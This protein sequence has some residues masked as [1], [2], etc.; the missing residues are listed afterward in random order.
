MQIWW[1]YLY[2]TIMKQ[3]KKVGSTVIIPYNMA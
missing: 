2:D 3:A 1:Q